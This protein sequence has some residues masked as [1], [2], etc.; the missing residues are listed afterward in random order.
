MILNGMSISLYFSLVSYRFSVSRQSILVFS[1]RL[2]LLFLFRFILDGVMDFG[3]FDYR[4]TDARYQDYVQ[5]VGSPFLS[6]LV[7]IVKSLPN[8]Q[9][10]LLLDP[11]IILSQYLPLL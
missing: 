3:L 2:K 7:V 6:F 4:D 11:S 1:L 10:T 5:P 8:Y 9:L